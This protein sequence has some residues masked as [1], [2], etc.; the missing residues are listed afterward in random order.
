LAQGHLTDVYSAVQEPIGRPVA[1]KVLKTTISPASPF[2]AALVREAEVLASFRSDNIP[3][4]LD[5]ERTENSMWLV[6][7]LVDGFTL[8]EM[9][10]NSPQVDP[11]AAVAI[12]MEITRALAQVHDNGIVH[13]H[14]TPA[15]VML[16]KDGRVS[17]VGF[18]DVQSDALSSAPEP[19]E[20]ETRL[21]TPMY[22][23]PEQILGDPIDSKSDLFSL[24]VVL[25]EM[26]SGKRPFEASDDR[27]AAHAIRHDEAP[28]LDS[29][30]SGL[31]R[32]L[33]QVVARC[34]QKLPSDRFGS[35][36]ELYAALDEVL[37]ATTSLPRKH[38]IALGLARARLIDRPPPV[39]MDR[40]DL[41]GMSAV[42]PSILPAFKMLGAMLALVIVG[43]ILIHVAFSKEI[44]TRAAVGRGPLELMPTE[45]GSLKVM[46]RPWATVIVDGQE[47][48]TTPFARPI[49]L[50]PGEHHVTLR[51]PA[52]PDERRVVQVGPGERVSLDVT[53]RIKSASK[54][55]AAVEIPAP[56]DSTP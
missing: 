40:P 1:V 27:M 41:L 35:A 45:A 8:R 19:V 23:S 2:A 34:L 49:P 39:D 52:A 26:L 47:V 17:L 53:M 33:V 9:I 10:D 13:S 31:P 24:G 37:S 36:R 44:E 7:E 12:A 50:A 21:G 5:F 32:A 51:H 30:A 46:A 25:Y 54:P 16:S 38:V 43:G 22:M 48:D 55:D 42:R 56:V 29:R 18:G 15:N 4:L 6:L 20:G 28:S 3:R 14:V 11:A